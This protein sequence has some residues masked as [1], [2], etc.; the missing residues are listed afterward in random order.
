MS[1]SVNRSFGRIAAAKQLDPVGRPREFREAFRSF[2]CLCSRHR[3]LL[4]GNSADVIPVLKK[5]A[6]AFRN[7]LGERYLGLA[8]GGSLVRGIATPAN[9]DVDYVLFVK[10]VDV[11]DNN[12]YVRLREVEKELTAKS[13]RPCDILHMSELSKAAFDPAFPVSVFANMLIDLAVPEED[14]VAGAR[15]AAAS[16]AELALRKEYRDMSGCDPEKVASKFFEKRGLRQDIALFSLAENPSPFFR[17]WG[18]EMLSIAKPHL[19]LRERNF[20]FPEELFSG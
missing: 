3:F 16:L 4:A 2:L 18:E 19:E 8:L 17:R 9:A 6:Y 12:L 7:I 13:F 10:G 5:M 14:L 1:I 11:C 20:P 15:K